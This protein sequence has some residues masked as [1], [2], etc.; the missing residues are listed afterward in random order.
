MISG[1]NLGA[2][3]QV[4]YKIASAK[5][6]YTLA[7]LNGSD[8]AQADNAG[9]TDDAK[10]VIG[11]FMTEVSS[12]DYSAGVTRNTVLHLHKGQIVPMV[13]SGVIT[14]GA[15]VGPAASG[16]IQGLTDNDTDSLQY[17]LGRALEAATSDGDEINIFVIHHDDYL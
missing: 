6:R 15:Y 3:I 9:A 13:A 7:K 5:V 11:T 1:A 12:A 10:T 14:A 8:L 17:I 4:A 2:N 16:K